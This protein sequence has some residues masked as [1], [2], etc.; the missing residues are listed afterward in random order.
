MIRITS[1][2]ARRAMNKEIP[3][4]IYLAFF[5]LFM[6]LLIVSGSSMPY[7]CEYPNENGI[8][9]LLS[10]G[11]TIVH[12][13]VLDNSIDLVAVGS[14]ALLPVYLF[15]A[16][17]AKD[18]DGE[19]D[20]VGLDERV[21]EVDLV[22]FGEREGEG[23]EVSDCVGVDV[24]DCVGVDVSDCV[25]ADDRYSVCVNSTAFEKAFELEKTLVCVN[26]SE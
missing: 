10:G 14:G 21:G 2:I 12:E 6:L 8:E 17:G 16:V 24:N 1:K 3:K 20:L 9:S 11:F 15:D 25:F 26:L 4:T 18:R 5:V 7:S 23:I 19:F 13:A 22:G